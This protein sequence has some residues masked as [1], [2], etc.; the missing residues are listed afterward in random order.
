MQIKGFEAVLT[1]E[2]EGYEYIFSND[3]DEADLLVVQ[4]GIESELN[5]FSFSG[6]AIQRNTLDSFSKWLI[7][8]GENDFY[9]MDEEGPIFRRTSVGIS[10][11]FDEDN[12]KSEQENLVQSFQCTQNALIEAGKNLREQLVKFPSRLQ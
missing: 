10:I 4:I 9:Q 1:M 2:I 12:D 3:P 7:Q 6:H 11:E 8:C 5:L